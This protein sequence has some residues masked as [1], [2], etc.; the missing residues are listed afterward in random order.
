MLAAGARTTLGPK[1]NVHTQIQKGYIRS[2]CFLDVSA[3]FD[4]VPHAYL[5]RKLNMIQGEN[6]TMGKELSN[7]KNKKSESGL[8]AIITS[9]N[10]ERDTG[11]QRN[12]MTTIFEMR[13]NKD[14]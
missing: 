6:I 9:E 13:Q 12:G 4:T 2:V 8:K 5:L 1:T 11:K 7:P 3:G 14:E 10:K